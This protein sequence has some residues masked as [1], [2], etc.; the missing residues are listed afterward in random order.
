MSPKKPKVL[1]IQDLKPERWT[2]EVDDFAELRAALGPDVINAFCRCFVHCDRLTS[3]VGFSQMSANF[4]GSDSVPFARDLQTAQ[5]FGV[6]TLRELSLAIRDLRSALGKSERL[7]AKAAPWV[8]LRE[9]EERWEGDGFF[10]DTRNK[11][12]FH[13]DRDTTERGLEALAVQ[14]RVVIMEGVGELHRGTTMRLGLEALFMGHEKDESDW[15]NFMTKTSDD[16][17]V[18]DL[19]QEVFIMALESAGVFCETVFRGSSGTG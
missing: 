7:D 13:A 11:I 19:I 16:W 14:G 5:W 8:R 4:F 15:R 1:L 6:G 3:L 2:L 17:N 10:R 12:A 18:G 9:I